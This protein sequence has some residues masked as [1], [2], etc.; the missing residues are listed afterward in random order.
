MA[1]WLFAFLTHDNSGSFHVK[2]KNMTLTDFDETWFLLSL[3]SDIHP[4][5]VSAL[6]VVCLQTLFNSQLVA[7]FH[8]LLYRVLA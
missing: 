6:Y 5:S 7:Q 8:P 3:S 1:G 4:Q 2:K